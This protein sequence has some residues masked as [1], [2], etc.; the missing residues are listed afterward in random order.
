MKSG[1]KRRPDDPPELHRWQ[2]EVIDLVAHS[3]LASESVF[4]GGAALSAVHLHHRRSEDVDFFLM[5][6]IEP[7]ELAPIT[8]ELIQLGYSVNLDARAPRTSLILFRGETTPV[9]K[10]DFAFYPYD[11]IDR[12]I[13]WRGLSVDSMVDTTVNKIQAVLTRFQPR[14]FVDLYFLLR[15]GGERDLDR[16]LVLAR[17]KFDAGADRLALARRL[18]LVHDVLQLPPLLRPVELD[19][20]VAFF[21]AQARALI[22]LG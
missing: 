22:Q 14:D 6:E 16:L 2:I 17:A 9:G 20:L 1:S 15:E 13:R 8:R 7:P 5:R 19:T 12:R 10:I 21:E 4:G 18:L 3:R 11:P